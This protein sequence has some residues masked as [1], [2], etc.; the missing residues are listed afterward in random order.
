MLIYKAKGSGGRQSSAVAH[1]AHWR[2][3]SLS[4]YLIP[5]S[6]HRSFSLYCQSLFTLSCNQDL[7]KYWLSFQSYIHLPSYPA[8][9][10]GTTCST[11]S[12]LS[13][14]APAIKGRPAQTFQYI[15]LLSRA[16]DSPAASLAPSN[17][18][19]GWQF[20]LQ[21]LSP[22]CFAVCRMTYS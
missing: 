21:S 9:D 14:I 20:P 16:S 15:I 7:H 4:P 8:G 11:D 22:A 12:A 5:Q 2:P 6:F 10:K 3:N 13:L 19:G 17:D 1:C 18:H